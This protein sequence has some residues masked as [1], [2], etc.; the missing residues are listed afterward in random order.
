MNNQ[1]M[2]L[3][4]PVD[5][6]Y[7]LIPRRLDPV[8]EIEGELFKKAIERLGSKG[9]FVPDPY[10]PYQI[11]NLN[12][13]IGATTPFSKKEVPHWHSAQTEVYVI[14]EGQADLLAKY[15][16]Q[17]RWRLFHGNPGDFLIVQPKVCH[18]FQWKSASGLA[19]VFK[20][21]QIAGVGKFPNGKTDCF[22]CPFYNNGCQLPKGFTPKENLKTSSNDSS[23]PV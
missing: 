22:S 16:W 18:W 20:A 13:Y 3:E 19:L 7:Q 10:E 4:N 17:V 6:L 5:Y 1:Q 21:P 9:I 23:S 15:H 14:Q 8:L 2:P 11:T 12:L